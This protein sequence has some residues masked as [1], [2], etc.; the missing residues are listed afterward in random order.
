MKGKSKKHRTV[1]WENAQDG[2]VGKSRKAVK[3]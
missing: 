1:K 3:V 2:K